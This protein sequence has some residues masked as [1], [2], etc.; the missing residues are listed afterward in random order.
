MASQILTA[1]D[2]HQIQ[3]IGADNLMIVFG[4]E[5]KSK[6]KDNHHTMCVPNLSITEAYLFDSISS[7][8][9]IFLNRSSIADRN[10]PAINPLSSN[11]GRHSLR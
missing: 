6:R 8:Q 9:L 5:D 11:S 10:D 7:I 1:K 3:D 4:G 2:P